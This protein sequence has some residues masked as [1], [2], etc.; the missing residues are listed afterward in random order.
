MYELNSTK[1]NARSYKTIEDSK[2][3][4]D[5]VAKLF[6]EQVILIDLFENHKIQ[7]SI[8]EWNNSNC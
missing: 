1:N 4:V 5:L 2:L 3:I 6:T 7:L 8:Y